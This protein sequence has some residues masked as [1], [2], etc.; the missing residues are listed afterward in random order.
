MN[1]LAALLTASVLSSGTL[2]WNATDRAFLIGMMACQ[3]ADLSSTIYALEFQDGYSEFNPVMPDNAWTHIPIKFG[4]IALTTLAT[5]RMS[6]H[7]AR[8]FVLG[9]VGATGCVPAG[10]NVR[11]MEAR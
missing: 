2:A 1:R 9:F 5:H 10:L 6:S 11:T 8:R 3:V 7:G 4:L